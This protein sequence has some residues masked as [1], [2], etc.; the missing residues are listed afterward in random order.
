MGRTNGSRSTVWIGTREAAGI[1]GWSEGRVRAHRQEFDG[2]M[3][4]NRLRYRRSLVESAAVHARQSAA[5]A[6]TSPTSH[7][8]TPQERSLTAYWG[9]L[10]GLVAAMVLGIAG[11]VWAAVSLVGLFIGGEPK[12]TVPTPRE[13]VQPSPGPDHPYI[14]RPEPHA[15]CRDGTVSFSMA[16]QGTCSH[17]GGVAYW[18]TPD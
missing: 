14:Q 9:P 3:A 12:P 5:P 8:A 18:L 1:L 7:A 6:A 2:R 17:H 15:I 16:R 13:V 4:N 10:I 11:L